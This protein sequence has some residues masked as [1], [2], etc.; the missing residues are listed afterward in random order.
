M[1]YDLLSNE[2]SGPVIIR[3]IPN[4]GRRLLSEQSDSV[5]LLAREAGT[6]DTF[7]DLAEGIDLSS[8]TP[9]VAVDFEVIC[10]A[11]DITGLIRVALFLGITESLPAL[12]QG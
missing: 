12:W 10:E 11:E 1:S 5:R 4:T 7:A 9:D 6:L 2:Q 8:Y 3:V